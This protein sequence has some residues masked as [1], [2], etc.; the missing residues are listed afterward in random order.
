[1]IQ[2]AYTNS[3]CSDIVDIFLEQTKKH[4]NLPLKL[5]SDY[6]PKNY[7]ENDF[8][9][10][11]NQD[12]YYNV[13]VNSLKKFNSEYFIYLQ[14]DFFLYSD[15]NEKKINEYLEIL[16]NNKEYSFVR[17][18]KSGSLNQKKIT[19][20]LYEIESSNPNIFAMQTSIWRTSDYITLMESVRDNKWLE[21]E[22]YNRIMIELNMKGLYHYDNE[23]KRGGNHYD[24]NVYPYIATALV[25]GKWNINEYPNELGNILKNYDIEINKRG[26]FNG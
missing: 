4:C 6:T 25:R 24:S 10:Y 17:L 20:T 12:A 18:I 3:V 15:V 21:N 11:D 16:K 19:D 14:E 1:M 9:L 13:W 8:F 23:N 7:N 22:N 5:I 26:I 2:V